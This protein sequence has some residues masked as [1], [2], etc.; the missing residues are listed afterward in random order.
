MS[1]PS[2]RLYRFAPRDRAGWILG[3]GAS[4]CLVLAG[5]LLLSALMASAGAPVPFLVAPV[6]GAAVFTF[7]RW[8]GRPMHE[9]VPVL[10]GWA[11]LHGRGS[12]R[13]AARV[14]LLGEPNGSPTRGAALPP[15]LVG[16]EILE[17]SAAWTRARRLGSVGLVA[18]RRDRCLS[19]VLRVQG[20]EFALVE[21]AEQERLLS[22]WGDV[23]AGFCRERGAV[24]RV[25]W[26]EWAAPAGL[27]EHLRYVG[28]EGTAA[29]DS[30]HRAAYLALVNQAGP[31]TTRHEVLV[32]VTIDPR[33]ARLAR[34]ST[35]AGDDAAAGALLEE[36]R[37]M[38]TRLENAELTVDVPL[39]PEELRE[40]LRVRADPTVLGALA[41]R[42]RASPAGALVGGHNFG[43]MV[44]DL[45]LGHARIDGSLHRGYWIAEWPRLDVGPGWLA[46]LLLHDGG[47]RTVTVVCEPVAPSRSQRQI[48]RDATKLA[49]DEEQRRKRGFRIGARHHRAEVA[50]LDREA[51]LVAGHAELEYVGFLTVTAADEES[52]QRSC[53]EY[54]QAAAQAG[55]EV[56]ALDG[57]HDAAFGA[58]L[59]IGRYPSARR[60]A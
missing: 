30:P 4:Q 53:A 24:S 46:R 55:F 23:L 42:R 60:F 50:V 39:S 15:F 7:G 3:L 10:A 38:T 2:E 1:V 31:M 26:S 43:P 14:P 29:A 20:R 25:A 44:V 9:W 36:L 5:A 22:A 16:L 45:H 51:E 40:V 54:E 19:G 32:T 27:E 35:N 18:D 11:G 17:A 6:A 13:G 49:S 41:T 52:L 58:S 47:V 12:I 48:D 57:Q 37:L 21:R 59:P 34:K 8:R 56:R 28:A 33:R